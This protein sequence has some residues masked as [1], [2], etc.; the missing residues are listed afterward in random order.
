MSFETNKEQLLS[1]TK[2]L[3]REWRNVKQDWNDKKA[4]EFE[5]KF[6][7]LIDSQVNHAFEAIDTITAMYNEARRDCSK[8]RG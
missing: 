4:D 7:Q 3:M 8:D 1:S 6:I 5:R 2:D